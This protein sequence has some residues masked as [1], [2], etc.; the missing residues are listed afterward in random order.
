MADQKTPKDN[1]SENSDIKDSK[2]DSAKPDVNSETEKPKEDIVNQKQAETMS[3]VID[4][5]KHLVGVS[6]GLLG[7]GAKAL[8]GLLSGL[9]D[10]MLSE[11]DANDSK[12]KDDDT[13]K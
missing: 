12:A 9:S 4:T 7:K 11:K 3:K 2:V 10:K 1:P 5:S 13:K 8:G 6:A